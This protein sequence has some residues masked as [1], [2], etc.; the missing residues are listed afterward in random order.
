[1]SVLED[2]LDQ[3]DAREIFDLEVSGPLGR[4]S[5]SPLDSGI[6]GRRINWLNQVFHQAGCP[7]G[8]HVSIRA[9]AAHRDAAQSMLSAP[10]NS[11]SNSQPVA[12]GRAMSLT[13]RSKVFPL[14]KGARLLRVLVRLDAVSSQTQQP[15][16]NFAGV[17]MV[18]HKE[19]PQTF[20]PHRR[21]SVGGTPAQFPMRLGDSRQFNAKSRGLVQPGTDGRERAPVRF[22]DRFAD[23]QPEAE[24][25]ASAPLLKRALDLEER[26]KEIRQRPRVKPNTCIAN[27]DAQA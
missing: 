25:P 19:Q 12:S 13:S 18:L 7:A 14:A 6:Q 9:E 8:R 5:D 20:A 21:R 22:S 11:F 26:L 17:V 3:R 24:A 23:R 16:E 4:F 15:R 27:V 10:R 2:F 1:M